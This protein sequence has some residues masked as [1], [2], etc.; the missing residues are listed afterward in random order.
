VKPIDIEQHRHA[1]GARLERSGGVS[2]FLWFTGPGWPYLPQY[3]GR[4][5]MGD[6]V[7]DEQAMAYVQQRMIAAGYRVTLRPKKNGKGIGEVVAA[8]SITFSET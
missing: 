8:W 3:V 4:D 7:T 6:N 1:T 5:D 2:F